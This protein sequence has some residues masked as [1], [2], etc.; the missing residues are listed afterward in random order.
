VTPFKSKLR[1]GMLLLAMAFVMPIT[2]SEEK[3][4]QTMFLSRQLLVATD[5]GRRRWR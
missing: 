2:F 3:R 1:P 5:S 4:G